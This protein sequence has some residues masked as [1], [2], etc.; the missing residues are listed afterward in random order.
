[1][2][3]VALPPRFD[4]VITNTNKIAPHLF[5]HPLHV[6][7]LGAS[8]GLHYFRRRREILLRCTWYKLYEVLLYS[9]LNADN[10]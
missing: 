4:K 1:M 9:L 5:A 2:F 6:L 10:N 3:I 7:V 8:V